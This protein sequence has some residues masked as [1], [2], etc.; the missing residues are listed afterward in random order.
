MTFDELVQVINVAL[1]LTANTTCS[2]IDIDHDGVVA[3]DE[4]VRAVASA[5]EGCKSKA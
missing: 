5:L 4:V 1:G 3:I 2:A